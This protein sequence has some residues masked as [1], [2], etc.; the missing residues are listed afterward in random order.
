MESDLLLCIELCIKSL[1]LKLREG[2]RL[3]L[4]ALL[5]TMYT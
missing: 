3:L 5:N 1:C 4:S 2:E